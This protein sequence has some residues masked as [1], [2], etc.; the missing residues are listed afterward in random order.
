MTSKSAEQTIFSQLASIITIMLLVVFI[1][2]CTSNGRYQQSKDSIPSRVPN[3]TEQINAVPRAEAISR[4]GNKDYTIRGINYQVLPTAKNF[5]ET[6]I[7]SFYGEKFHGHLTSN[8]EIYNMY[9]MTAAHKNLP[10]PTY[11]TV[12]NLDNNRTAIVRVNDRGPFHPGRIIDL[13]YSAAYKLG[14]SGTARVEIEAI[15]DFT[16]AQTNKTVKNNAITTPLKKE[17]NISSKEKQLVIQVLATQNATLAKNTSNSLSNAY[18]TATQA[19]EENGLY[20]VIVGPFNSTS[21]RFLLLQQ[22]KR[23]GYEGA[24]GKEMFLP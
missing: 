22:L 11:V 4:G 13:S 5:K 12:K 24:F 20:R 3:Q 15:T 2:S 1:T 23:S 14:I 8:G 19:I 16:A 10:L 17:N 9:S 7:A 21:E 18:G 6:G